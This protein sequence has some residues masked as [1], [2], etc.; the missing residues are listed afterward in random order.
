MKITPK[1]L[2]GFVDFYN[3]RNPRSKLSKPASPDDGSALEDAILEILGGTTAAGAKK[4]RDAASKFR[5][6]GHD[7]PEFRTIMKSI[8]AS[9]KLGL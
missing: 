9:K 6:L 5:H 8:I 2:N 7:R 3:A 1:K 4:H